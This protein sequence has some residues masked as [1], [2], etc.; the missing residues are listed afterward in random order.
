[1][2]YM[3]L[4]MKLINVYNYNN[5]NNYYI[6]IMSYLISKLIKNKT[7]YSIPLSIKYYDILNNYIIYSK[8]R[9]VKYPRPLKKP[10]VLKSYNLKNKR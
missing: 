3:R 8:T 10:V 9:S 4:E 6:I 1:M 5:Y 7:S 2:E